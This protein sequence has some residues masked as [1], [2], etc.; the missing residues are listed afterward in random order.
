MYSPLLSRVE[1]GA[2]GPVS[3]R[4]WAGLAETRLGVGSTGPVTR[5]WGASGHAVYGMTLAE[6]RIAVPRAHRGSAYGPP[7]QIAKRGGACVPG[8]TFGAEGDHGLAGYGGSALLKFITG[9]SLA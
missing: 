7:R 2:P 9:R 5:P 1:A 3:W 4:T 6:R 8:R